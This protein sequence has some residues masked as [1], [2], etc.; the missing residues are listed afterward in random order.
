[1]YY[2]HRT[3]TWGKIILSH[4][5]LVLFCCCFLLLLNNSRYC[6]AE[7]KASDSDREIEQT[8][9]Y[10]IM[11]QRSCSLSMDVANASFYLENSVEFPLILFFLSLPLFS[12]FFSFS[13]TCFFSSL[14]FVLFRFFLHRPCEIRKK[15]FMQYSIR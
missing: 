3:T 9:I 4:I 14:C 6:M 8:H 7:E 13:L 10:A 2:V 11:L 1:M 12:F 15:N 5:H